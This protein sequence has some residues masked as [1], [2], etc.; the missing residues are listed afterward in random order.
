[1]NLIGELWNLNEPL[2][3]LIFKL[4]EYTFEWLKIGKKYNLYESKQDS[5]KWFKWTWLLL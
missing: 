4:G 5:L 3:D 2:D 1:M